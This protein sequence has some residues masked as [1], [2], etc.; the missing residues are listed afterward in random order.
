M[1]RVLLWTCLLVV[2]VGQATAEQPA[3][4]TQPRAIVELYLDRVVKGD[5][6]AVI[7]ELVSQVPS[8][9]SAQQLEL[10]KTQT[11]TM[12]PLYGKMLGYEFV[13][14][15]QAGCLLHIVYFVKHEKH[16]IAWSFYF[17]KP[18]STWKLNSFRWNDR[19]EGVF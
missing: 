10:I 11:I 19:F 17:Y 7:D 4:P 8:S 14:E 5:V 3:P 18:E 16:P 2:G 12:L 13:R 9:A 6:A 15:Q 1:M